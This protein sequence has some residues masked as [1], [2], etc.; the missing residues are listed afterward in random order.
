MTK[1][2]LA[3]RWFLESAGASLGSMRMRLFFAAIPL[4]AIALAACGDGPDSPA[5][6]DSTTAAA[7]ETVP[8][9]TNTPGAVPS[10]EA[11]VIP[12]GNVEAIRP[13]H[14][15]VVKQIDTRSPNPNDPSNGVCVQVSFEDLPENFQW[16]R[17]IFNEEEVTVSPD[18]LLVAPSSAQQTAPEG[19]SMCYMPEEGLPVGVHTVTV[20]IQNPRNLSEPTRQIVQWQFEVVP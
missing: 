17:M 9:T 12:E 1:G 13:E 18:I 5:T 8:A 19:G 15:A 6:P 11:P 2:S 20:G 7:T 14:G 4:A 10:I 3:V 16:I